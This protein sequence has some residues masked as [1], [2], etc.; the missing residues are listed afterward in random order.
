M[1]VSPRSGE[2]RLYWTGTQNGVFSVRNAYHMAEERFK[3][4]KG[5]CSNRENKRVLWKKL[6]TCRVSKVVKNFLWKACK[7][8]LATKDNLFKKHITN[9]PLCP[10]CDLEVETIGHI[11]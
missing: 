11:F 3:V 2:D 4:D 10:V 5:S 9:D 8:I 7:N 6:W 1:A